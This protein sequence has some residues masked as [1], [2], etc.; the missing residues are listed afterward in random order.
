MNAMVSG[1]TLTAMVYQY[2]D[3]AILCSVT[4]R[5]DLGGDVRIYTKWAV[6]PVKNIIGLEHLPA[7]WDGY[8][9]PPVPKR[10]ADLAITLLNQIAGL[11]FDELPAP[12]V[13][14]I[15]GGGVGLVWN[16][17]TRQLSVSSFPDQTS[18]YLRCDSGEP[19]DEGEVSPWMTG[20]L[21]NVVS[22][23]LAA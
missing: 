18:E 6:D 17:G 5:H 22:W 9:S 7:N 8:Q 3:P 19:F 4:G 11:G 20:R 23:V 16:V 10:T 2:Q 12:V 13:Q 15:S 21:R 14:P 1:A